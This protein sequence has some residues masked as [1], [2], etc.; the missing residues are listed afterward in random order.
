MKKSHGEFNLTPFGTLPEAQLFA[1][2][3]TVGIE[4]SLLKVCWNLR[5]P[6]D[7]LILPTRSSSPARLEGLWE[8]TCFEVFYKKRGSSQ[9]E[10]WNFSSSGDW[11]HF[12]F[13][14]PRQRS[15][16][17]IEVDH[18]TRFMLNTNLECQLEASIGLNISPMDLEFNLSCVLEHSTR[19]K[20]YWATKHGSARPDFHD[21]SLWLHFTSE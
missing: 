4:N 13:F 5:G 2:R 19:A 9:Y 1:L 7:E 11:A 6:L 20:S 10:E 17:S 16:E 21:S 18:S 12:S 3:A 14:A 8:K 15:S